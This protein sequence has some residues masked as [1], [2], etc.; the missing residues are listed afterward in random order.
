MVNIISHELDHSILLTKSKHGDL[1]SQFYEY[2]ADPLMIRVEGSS[3]GLVKLH[4]IDNKILISRSYGILSSDGTF[5][6]DSVIVATKCSTG[7][8]NICLDICQKSILKWKILT[9]EFINDFYAINRYHGLHGKKLIEELECAI[10]E[11]IIRR[12]HS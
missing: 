7:S 3:T 10:S 4:G 8:Y 2:A 6:V 5:T 9:N 1:V 11:G 12:A